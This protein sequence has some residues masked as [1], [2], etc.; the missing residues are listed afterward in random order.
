[1]PMRVVKFV[2][3][4]SGRFFGRIRCWIRGQCQWQEVQFGDDAGLHKG[5]ICV[6]CKREEINVEFEEKN[7]AEKQDAASYILADPILLTI[8]EVKSRYAEKRR[9]RK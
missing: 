3:R 4:H 1:M 8:Y 2:L 6:T 9:D 5:R 7:D